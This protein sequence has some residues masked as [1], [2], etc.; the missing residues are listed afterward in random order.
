MSEIESKILSLLDSGH[1]IDDIVEELKIDKENLADIIID[2]DTN[3]YVCLKD[4]SWVL[5]KEG[6]NVLN[7]IKESLRNLKLDYL[8]GNIGRDEFLEK[9]KKL[10]YVVLTERPKQDDGTTKGIN[11]TCSKCGVDNNAGSRYCYRC[12]LPLSV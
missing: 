7:K 6:H 3:G 12:G 9:K 2:L 11:I 10:E 1:R 8:D 5:T 4:K